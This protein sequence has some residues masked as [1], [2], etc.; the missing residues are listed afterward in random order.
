MGVRECIMAFEH[1]HDEYKFKIVCL[2]GYS[3]EVLGFIK[4]GAFLNNYHQR[5]S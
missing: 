2:I 4:L 5:S 1:I 3:F